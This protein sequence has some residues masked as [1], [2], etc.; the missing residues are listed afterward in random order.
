MNIERGSQNEVADA[1]SRNPQGLDVESKN[2]V[3][4]N[5]LPSIGLTSRNQL[6]EEQWKDPVFGKNYDYLENGDSVSNINGSIYINW[7]QDFNLIDG[8]LFYSKFVSTKGELRVDNPTSLKQA[9]LNKFHDNSL[10]GHLGI[11]KTYAKLKY[12]CYFPF[13]PKTVKDYVSSCDTCQKY[14]YKNIKPPV[15]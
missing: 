3:S 5:V 6:I 1:L 8:L 10:A 11:R 14:N 15:Y 12:A 9:I 7:S 2:N 13:I 4:C